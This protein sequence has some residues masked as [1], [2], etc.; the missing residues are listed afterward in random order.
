MPSQ[1]GTRWSRS[2]NESSVCGFPTIDQCRFGPATRLHPQS[3]PSGRF[4]TPEHTLQSSLVG[5]AERDATKCLLA[6]TP[7][8][9][10]WFQAEAQLSGVL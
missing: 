2:E 5:D 6:L 4:N 7:E 8:T 10:A 9:A 1:A 3:S